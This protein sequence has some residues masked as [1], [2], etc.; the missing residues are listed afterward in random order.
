MAKRKSNLKLLEN[1]PDVTGPNIISDAPAFA[2]MTVTPDLAA[3]WL[4]KTNTNNRTVVEA[5]V[6]TLASDMLSGRWRGKNGEAIRFDINGRL[7]DGQ[8]RLWA[9]VQSGCN[10]VTLLITGVD[11]E[12]YSTIGVGRKKKLADFLGPVHH[13][14][15][16]NL[17]AS[18]IKL[19]DS[20]DKGRLGTAAHDVTSIRDLEETY[21]KYKG[22]AESCARIASLRETRVLLNPTYASFIHFV[23]TY[24]GYGAQVE[25]FMQTLGNGL[26]L[27]EDNPIYH[28]RKYLLTLRGPIADRKRPGKL[29]VLALAIKA[30]N[31]F[32][33]EKR[34]KSLQF[35]SNEEFPS[36]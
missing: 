26:G 3:N 16:T 4:E 25:V 15:N 11:P 8:H 12:D 33:D 18:T 1:F 19:V 9:C 28:L 14:K 20:W 5:H 34:I 29:Y 36:I 13:E 17:M 23:A 2:W 31:A 32:R 6:E 22:I 24:E 21:Y 10:F 27:V 35:K 7:V 30:W